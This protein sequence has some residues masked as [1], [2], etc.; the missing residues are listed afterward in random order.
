MR[1]LVSRLVSRPV[2]LSRLVRR[3]VSRLPAVGSKQVSSHHHSSAPQQSRL[4]LLYGR[5]GLGVR[6]VCEENEEREK[7][8]GLF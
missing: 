6:G 4:S 2:S 3:L 7:R 5:V 1:R 8:G